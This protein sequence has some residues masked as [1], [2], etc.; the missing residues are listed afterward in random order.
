[1]NFILYL[2]LASIKHFHLLS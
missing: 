2:I 1:L